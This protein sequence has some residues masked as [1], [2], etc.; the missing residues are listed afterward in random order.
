M[1]K[2]GIRKLRKT[3]VGRGYTQSIAIHR[4]T[5]RA[6]EGS[7]AHSSLA[8]NERT[9]SHILSLSVRLAMRAGAGGQRA[10]GWVKGDSLTLSTRP[11][12]TLTA[13]AHF[14]MPLNGTFM[15]GQ[16]YQTHLRDHC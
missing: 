4:T 10:P 9:L 15:V 13:V 7:L 14:P 5:E 3:E 6:K 2:E 1:L 8:E 11:P 12:T 16:L